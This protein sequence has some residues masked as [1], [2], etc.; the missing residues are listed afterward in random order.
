MKISSYSTQRD[1]FGKNDL[2][3][4]I[5]DAVKMSSGSCWTR[6]WKS[7]S[8]VCLQPRR[9]SISW[10]ALKEERLAGRQRGLSTQLYSAPMRPHLESCVQAW[11]PQQKKD[12][13]HLEQVL[14]KAP[15][16]IRRLKNLSC[17]ERLR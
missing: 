8:S 16:M 2:L 9:P 4:V 12:V 11:G 3:L 13:R 10:P 15:K 7:T 17:E 5:R 14:R 1:L 6:S